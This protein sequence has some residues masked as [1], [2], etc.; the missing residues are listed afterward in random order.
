[1]MHYD[2]DIRIRISFGHWLHIDFNIDWIHC[3]DYTVLSHQLPH[4]NKTSE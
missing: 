2:P 1:M 4:K 3:T